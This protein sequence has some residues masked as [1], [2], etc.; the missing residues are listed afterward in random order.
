M[1]NKKIKNKIPKIKFNLNKV[2]IN[3]MIFNYSDLSLTKVNNVLYLSIE[4][5]IL[6]RLPSSLNEF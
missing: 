4:N 6:S 3:Q 2:Q 1:G 5:F